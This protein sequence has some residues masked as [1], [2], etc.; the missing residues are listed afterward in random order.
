M[1]SLTLP[2]S[3]IASL[4]NV[5]AD[6]GLAV[7]RLVR[8]QERTPRPAAELVVF[9]KKAVISVKPMPALERRLGVELVPLADGRS[10]IALDSPISLAELELRMAD[11]LEDDTLDADEREAFEA[12]LGILRDA[13]RSSDVSLLRRNII[14]LHA[15]GPHSSP[16]MPAEP[17]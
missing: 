9:G 11:T 7:A 4:S 8:E 12:L 17:D 13:R 3:L 14:V 5:H 2:E 1:V 16:T 10:L 6:L 15:G